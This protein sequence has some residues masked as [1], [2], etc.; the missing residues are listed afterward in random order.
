MK[1]KPSRRD[2]LHRLSALGAGAIFP[3]LLAGATQP[4]PSGPM[5]S[6]TVTITA[7]VTGVI[8]P[9][10]AGLEQFHN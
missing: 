10:F 4:V 2:I 6:A 9:A 8:G 3:E 7:A 1:G 5:T